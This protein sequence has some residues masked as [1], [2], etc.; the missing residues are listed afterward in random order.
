[1]EPQRTTLQRIVAWNEGA[2]STFRARRSAFCV[3][4]HSAT[5]KALLSDVRRR[6]GNSEKSCRRQSPFSA[7]EEHDT[8]AGGWKRHSPISAT[9]R[10]ATA[11]AP[12]RFSASATS[13]PAE[14][15]RAVL[16]PR[17]SEFSLLPFLRRGLFSAQCRKDLSRL[18]RMCSLGAQH[19]SLLESPAASLREAFH[20]YPCVTEHRSGPKGTTLQRIVA[21][22]SIVIR[23]GEVA[24]TPA[25]KPNQ[26]NRKPNQTPLRCMLAHWKDVAGGPSNKKRPL[27]EKLGTEME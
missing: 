14:R 8:A 12:E 20:F 13:E 2:D 3:Y 1:M 27:N 26:T 16:K 17:T 5:S 11:N 9:S 21:R 10:A 15:S 22:N 25:K 24:L 6:A 19:L 18:L 23:C 4:V 7:T